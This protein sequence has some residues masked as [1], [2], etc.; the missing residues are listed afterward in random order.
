MDLIRNSEDFRPESYNPKRRLDEE[1]RCLEKV[2]TSKNW[3]ERK[4]LVL[5]EVHVSMNELIELA[6]GDKKRSLATVK[7][8]E[9]VNFTLIASR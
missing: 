9:I 2:D 7:P 4:K 1:I 8:A 6:K 3:E 5:K